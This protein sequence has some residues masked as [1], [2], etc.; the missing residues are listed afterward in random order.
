MDAATK[1]RHANINNRMQITF[2]QRCY[3]VFK[4]TLTGDARQVL[5]WH[6]QATGRDEPVCRQRASCGP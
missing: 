4:Q 2:S 6:R 5:G 1:I 3:Y